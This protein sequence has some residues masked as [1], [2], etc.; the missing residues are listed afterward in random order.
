MKAPKLSNVLVAVKSKQKVSGFKLDDTSIH[1]W[2]RKDLELCP[3]ANASSLKLKAQNN[4]Q[5]SI[6][7]KARR[8]KAVPGQ[9]QRI[10]AQSQPDQPSKSKS[11][12]TKS[13]GMPPSV[14]IPPSIPSTSTIESNSLRRYLIEDFLYS[15][16]GDSLLLQIALDHPHYASYS[17]LYEQSG[18]KPLR[19]ISG[20]TF[21]QIPCV[22]SLHSRRSELVDGMLGIYFLKMVMVRLE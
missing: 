21:L 12:P 10:A 13:K 18:P 5:T 16:V 19:L 9:S 22:V 4:F 7:R 20:R 15:N 8:V 6:Q 14:P 3:A 2:F 11:K 17:A 1:A